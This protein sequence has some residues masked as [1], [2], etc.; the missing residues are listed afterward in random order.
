MNGVPCWQVVIM[1][2]STRPVAVTVAPTLAAD[3]SLGSL[4][5]SRWPSRSRQFGSTPAVIVPLSS[6]GADDEVAGEDETVGAGD[7]ADGDAE[8]GA[9]AGAPTDSPEL[10]A[11]PARARITSTGRLMRRI[12]MVAWTLPPPLTFPASEIKPAAA[13]ACR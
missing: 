9:G 10:L 2:G 11:Q 3:F 12:V 13:P 7:D 5:I 8:A 1:P 6:E 4:T